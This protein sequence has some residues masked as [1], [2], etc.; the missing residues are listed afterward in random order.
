MNSLFNFIIKPFEERT[1]NKLKINESE[2]ILNTE[3]QNH[4]Y[5]SRHG[6]VI[7]IP[8]VG[9][10]EVNIGDEI[11]VHHNVFR[12]FYDIRGKEK[13]SKSYFK[14]DL[15]FVQQDQ[16][17]AYKSNDEWKAI[18]GFCFIKPLKEN[19]SFSLEKEIVGKGVVKYS[20]GY[21]DENALVSF[22]PG[23]EYEF[24]IENERLYRVPNK[25]ITI[26]YE[27]Q[28]DEKEYNPSWSQS[29]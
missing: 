28:G 9:C 29:S 10:T 1:N 8:L 14:E 4:Q 18:K 19:N 17:Y 26:K 7:S 23:F 16:V 27:H 21:V 13:N 15:F 24:F 2:L 22:K 11:I 12:R 25:F 6:I 3:M 20:D 5:V